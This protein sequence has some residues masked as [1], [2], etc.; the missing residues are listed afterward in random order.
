MKFSLRDHN[1]HFFNIQTYLKKH[2]MVLQI[3]IIL[4]VNIDVVGPK[5]SGFTPFCSSVQLHQLARRWSNVLCPTSHAYSRIDIGRISFAYFS[6]RH[7]GKTTPVRK[8]IANSIVVLLVF[9]ILKYAV[10]PISVMFQFCLRSP[11]NLIIRVQMYIHLYIL[12][13]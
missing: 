1:T 4:W 5:T 9:T 12:H 13:T 3:G 2:S 6:M 11:P 8:I 10:W 7:A